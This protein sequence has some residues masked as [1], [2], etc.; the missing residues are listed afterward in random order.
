MIFYLSSNVARKFAV[1]QPREILCNSLFPRV[2]SHIF[3]FFHK[4]ILTKNY[5][6]TI[7]NIF[8]DVNKGTNIILIHHIRAFDFDTEQWLTRS[9]DDQIHFD[10]CYS[11]DKRKAIVGLKITSQSHKFQKD[12]FLASSRFK[13]LAGA[14]K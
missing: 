7:F 1:S 14:V 13:S 2:T 3:K 11:T 8:C 12:R 6:F 9:F 10:I 4:T 5:G